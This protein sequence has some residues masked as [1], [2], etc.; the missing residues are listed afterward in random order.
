MITLHIWD[1]DGT[2]LDSMRM[3]DS[4][5]AN[6]LRSR[7]I[8]PPDNLAETLDP[9]TFPE[10]VQYLSDHFDLNESYD[11]VLQG[12]MQLV[13]HHYETDLELFPGIREELDACRQTGQHMVM[14][15]N[16]P[17]YMVEAGLTRTGVIGYF[18][19]IFISQEIGIPK[20]NPEAFRYV[21]REM[22]VTPENTLVYED[23]DFAIR[24]ARE[25]GCR[26]KVY[27]RYRE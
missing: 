12:M 3:W 7:G 16:S 4:V 11:E 19:H 14:L 8:T 21:C 27:D 9:L 15:T 13:Q 10:A 5:N 6:Y 23:S 24:A 26:V 18:E 25:A 22:H 2:I 17:R 20:D 1:C